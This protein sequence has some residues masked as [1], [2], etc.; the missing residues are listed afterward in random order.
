MVYKA[1]FLFPQTILIFAVPIIKAM[2]QGSESFRKKIEQLMELFK[3]F[4]EKMEK[5]GLSENNPYSMN[6]KMMLENY[7]RMKN[8]LP[9][10]IPENLRAPFEHMLNDLIS[11][12]R[13]EI[14]DL[15]QTP[16]QAEQSNQTLEEIQ[17]KLTQG[18]LSPQE[19]DELLDKLISLKKG[20]S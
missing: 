9:D 6:F 18:N 8:F 19:M 12:L 4:A 14:G 15:P 2:D 20:N 1:I 13:D 16:V 3:R 5:E 10:D 17:Q 7:D 11:K